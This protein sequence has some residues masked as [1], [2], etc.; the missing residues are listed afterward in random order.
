MRDRREK[1][2]MPDITPDEKFKKFD[3]YTSG[4][5]Y[6]DH[7]EF[8]RWG[9]DYSLWRNNLIRFANEGQY[10]MIHIM[11]TISALS[12]WSITEFMSDILEL[13]KQFGGH[14]FH[15]SLNLVRFP[16]F[17]N[18]NVLPEDLKQAQA[19]KIET[20]LSNAVGLSSSET[21]QIERI[22]TYLRNVNRSQEDTDSQENKQ[23]DLKS[24]TQQYADRKSVDLS[25]VFPTEFVKWFNTI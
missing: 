17:Q 13:R 19:D 16:S 4:E 25:T 24:F 11:M 22:I 18:L 20:W 2:E 7:A 8:I 23:H 10:S 1:Q 5:G 12:I 9:L 3:L 15:M 14:Q 6:G 21:N